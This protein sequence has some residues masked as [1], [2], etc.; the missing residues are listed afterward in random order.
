MKEEIRTFYTDRKYIPAWQKQFYVLGGLLIIFM[1][2]FG[3]VRYLTDDDEFVHYIGYAIILLGVIILLALIYFWFRK[4]TI[5]IDSDSIIHKES[6]SK[7]QQARYSDIEEICYAQ[8]EPIQGQL[9]I[10]LPE[11]KFHI[12][13]YGFNPDDLKIIYKMIIEKSKLPPGKYHDV[14]GLGGMLEICSDWGGK[15]SDESATP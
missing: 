6:R 14:E 2:S 15:S 12:F 1:S 8:I 10:K 7:I 4:S 11:N 9:A 5:T 3:S 13:G